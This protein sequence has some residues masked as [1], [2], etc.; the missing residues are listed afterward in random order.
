MA[1]VATSCAPPDDGPSK[2]SFELGPSL[3]YDEGARPKW[4]N[5]VKGV[6]AG[7]HGKVEKSFSAAVVTSVP[8]G[9][10]KFNFLS[11]QM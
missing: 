2:C 10:H 6:A 8:L 7:F 9:I 1:T 4:V 3:K 5:Y 11:R